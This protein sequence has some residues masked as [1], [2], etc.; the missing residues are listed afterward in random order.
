MYFCS[1]VFINMKFYVV[2]H[3]F[4]IIFLLFAT[5]NCLPFRCPRGV[6][7]H[8]FFAQIFSH[9]RFLSVFQKWLRE[10]I[11]SHP[12]LCTHLKHKQ[13][14]NKS[15]NSKFSVGNDHQELTNGG[16]II[17]P[18]DSCECWHSLFL[19]RNVREDTNVQHKIVSCCPQ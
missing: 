2:T 9:F 7:I 4:E 15:K 14:S 13:K 10:E 11:P 1:V 5:L 19:V 3:V 18:G 12:Q 8:Y 6:P 17:V 16:R